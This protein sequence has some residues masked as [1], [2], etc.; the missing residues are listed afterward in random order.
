MAKRK[1]DPSGGRPPF[2]DLTRPQKMHRCQFRK[3]RDM[4]STC[5]YVWIQFFWHLRAGDP[6]VDLIVWEIGERVNVRPASTCVDESQRDFRPTP[7]FTFEVWG[8]RQARKRIQRQKGLSGDQV[9]AG[10][11]S[12]EHELWDGMLKAIVDGL[13][14]KHATEACRK[15]NSGGQPFAAVATRDDQGLH[16]SEL[17]LAWKNARGPSVAA[18]RRRVT[19]SRGRTLPC[20]ERELSPRK[21]HLEKL[22]RTRKRQAEAAK[23]HAAREAANAEKRRP[24]VRRQMMK[25]VNQTTR[26]LPQP[27]SSS[28][29]LQPCF[30]LSLDQ[31]NQV[32]RRVAPQVPLDRLV[33]I[34]LNYQ[35]SD[36]DE[37]DNRVWEYS[38]ALLEPALKQAKAKRLTT[39]WRKLNR[40]QKTFF[41]FLEFV[42]QVDNGGV[43]QFL[44]NSP[45]LSFAALEAMEEIGARQLACD[46]HRVLEEMVGKAANV[47]H[48]RERAADEKLT[49]RRRWAAFVAGYKELTS[50]ARIER[51]IFAGKFKAKLFRKMAV[52][53]ESTLPLF[54]RISETAAA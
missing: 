16:R 17:T 40:P 27:A 51:Y 38:Y 3:A 42:G 22:A 45:E 24:S 53:V 54:G 15:Y 18:I 21:Q 31:G 46:Y 49:D 25:R 11:R 2:S 13:N 20:D 43:W 6:R 41:T 44:Y 19:A 10:L 23:K 47:S 52:V 48:L 4:A 12:L 50:A 14:Y 35:W 28:S 26:E 29:L 30:P 8:Y 36:F 37:Y 32:E 1:S 5:R 39:L 34:Q 9:D 7:P 33:E